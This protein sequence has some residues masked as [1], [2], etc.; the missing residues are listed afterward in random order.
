MV[1]VGCSFIDSSFAITDES[2]PDLE[3][4][5]LCVDEADELVSDVDEDA[6]KSLFIGS[7]V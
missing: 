6:G 4:L 7:I 1:T 3:A 2:E 5:Q